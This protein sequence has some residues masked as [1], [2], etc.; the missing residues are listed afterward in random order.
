MFGNEIQQ[1]RRTKTPK[2]IQLRHK[3]TV[4]KKGLSFVNKITRG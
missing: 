2:G 3:L 1:K 4:A